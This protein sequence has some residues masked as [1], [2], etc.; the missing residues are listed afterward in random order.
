MTR[1]LPSDRHRTVSI[2]NAWWLLLL[3]GIASV[4]FGL[5]AIA[6]PVE[7]L[8]ALMLIFGVYV[9]ADGVF[10][11]VGAIRG[12]G[13]M[14]RWWLAMI[15]LISL[16]AGAVALLW[17]GLTAA[18]LVILFG[19][20]T[21]AHGFFEIVG[22]IKLRK[23]IHNEWTLGLAGL[24]SVVVGLALMVMPGLG[25]LVLLWIIGAWAIVFGVLF[26]VLSFFL[27]KRQRR[28]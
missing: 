14:P 2:E 4:V 3:R 21:A 25:A 23:V 18:T 17:P 27:R 24:L 1:I 22:A 12:G 5:V 20:W 8:L 10:S 7:S 26:I 9:I 6:W 28:R 13:L 11:L 19:F 16:G 15:G